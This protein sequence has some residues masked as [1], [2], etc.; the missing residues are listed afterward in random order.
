MRLLGN[1]LGGLLGDL[2]GAV[3]NEP[4]TAVH[5]VVR[6]LSDGWVSAPRARDLRISGAKHTGASFDRLVRAEADGEHAWAVRD[7]RTR[8]ITVRVKRLGSL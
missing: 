2:L 3:D 5:S 7:A 6:P 4:T 1:L 8:Q